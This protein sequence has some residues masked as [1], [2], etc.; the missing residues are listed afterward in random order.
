[1]PDATARWLTALPDWLYTRLSRA[2]LC[3]ARAQIALQP[4]VAKYIDERSDIRPRTRIN[5][6]L[7]MRRA[8]EYFGPDRDPRT[9][10]EAEGKTYLRWLWDRNSGAPAGRT[11]KPLKQSLDP[12]RRAKIIPDNPF[13]DVKAPQQK[14]EARKVFIDAATTARVMA[15]LP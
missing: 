2:D 6:N 9:L 14:N 15:E 3:P 4:L 10:T 13:R 7:A 11:L 12:A 5:M 1:P 8:V